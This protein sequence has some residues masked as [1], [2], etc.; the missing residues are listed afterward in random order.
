MS[1]YNL[2]VCA[3]SAMHP[4]GRKSPRGGGSPLLQQPLAASSAQ[5]PR[6]TFDGGSIEVINTSDSTIF[7][8]LYDFH[9]SG[10]EKLSLRKGDQVS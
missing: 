8:A 6:H 2:R 10:D 5:L 9:G 7:V 3:E 1:S 4:L